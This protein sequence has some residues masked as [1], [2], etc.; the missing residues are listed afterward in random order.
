MN[1]IHKRLLYYFILL[2][3]HHLGSSSFTPNI[4]DY[5]AYGT[6]IAMNQH[7]LVLAQNNNE[8]ST[9]FLQFAPYNDTQSLLSSQCSITYPNIT[10]TFIYTVALGK[11]QQQNQTQFFFA[12]EFID[13][14]NGLFIGMIKYNNTDQ[15]SS[16]PITSLSCNTSFIYSIE[17]I[18]NYEHQEYYIIGADPQGLYAYG[19]SNEFVFVYDSKNTSNFH[20]WNGSL[21]W[22]DASF[23]PHAVDISDGFGVVA[24]FI[25]NNPN[26]TVIY[27]PMIYLFNF[28]VSNS[29]HPIVVDQYHPVP[30]QSTWQ[31]LLTNADADLYGGKYDMSVSIN[32]Q[33]YVLVGMQFINRVFLLSV[34]VTKPNNLTY[35]SRHTNG[36]SLG[37]GKS[38]A[39]LDNGIAAI[40]INVY[41]LSYEWSSSH[42][43][44]F[45]INADEYDS[46]GT[47]LS[48]YPNNHQLVPSGFSSMFLNIV[49]SP[50]SLALLDDKGKIL[51]FSPTQPGYYP[52][53][54]NTGRNPYV[55]SPKSCMPGSYKNKSGIHNCVL[56]PLGTKNDGNS[57]TQCIPCSSEAFC[58]LGSV[59]DVSP[60]ALQIISQAFSYPLSPERTIFEDI[61]LQYV[62]T[63]HP[64]RCILIS[65]LFWTLMVTSLV[66]VII[67]IMETLKLFVQDQ[68]VR[69]V[70]KKLKR[71]L[72]HTD[73]VGEGEYWIGGLIS[74]AVIVLVSFA[75]AF[76]HSYLQLYPIE[77]SSPSPL[78]CDTTLRNAKF[79][80]SVQSLAIPHAATEQEMFDLLNSQQFTLHIDFINTLI[81]CQ[82][83]LVE[84]KVGLQWSALRWSFCNVSDG[85]IKLSIPIPDQHIPVRISLV[86]TKTIGA[87][88]IGLSGTARGKDKYVL[89]DLFFSQ[90]FSKEGYTLSQALPVDIAMTKVINETQPLAGDESEY[91][92]IFIPT[93]TA[94]NNS[95]FV[96][97]DQYVRLSLLMT[98]LTITI[99]ETPY[100]V[101]N[102]QQP[103]AKESEVIFRNLLFTVVCFEIFG[104]AFLSYKLVLKPLYRVIMK[105][106]RH[107]N[108]VTDLDKKQTNDDTIHSKDLSK[109]NIIDID[110]ISSNL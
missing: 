98:T 102:V 94:D 26:S 86:D 74:F 14:Q 105:K 103:I 46:D 5:D 107:R 69:T 84:T 29:Y 109:S 59:A 68:R 17:Y 65:P 93:F 67:I 24:G 22:S 72:R 80:T 43:F 70:R 104:L 6:K 36:R 37:N 2:C 61:L 32:E 42:I 19:F 82:A 21:T 89:K 12:G 18:N 15:N 85:I 1:H 106:Y 62:F 108:Q 11:K 7:L 8:A 23:I 79:R 3:I 52:S 20:I 40:L 48:V 28:N 92:G 27:S 31:D 16:F 76:S 51:I 100:Y 81:I 91:S 78:S 101:K 38:V 63:I 95:L 49:S 35:I 96:S 88:R 34:N 47:P 83:I 9:F 33:G 58:P 64:G 53:I 10:D 87:L 44:F 73:L 50:S 90:S 54:E 66:I 57:N 71:V 110:Y 97:N 25:R 56:C 77:E 45:D 60:S 99:T 39:W 4:D 13:D 41:T 30:R 75:Y 55:T